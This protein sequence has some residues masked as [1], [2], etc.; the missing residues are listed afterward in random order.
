MISNEGS[1]LVSFVLIGDMKIDAET[2]L[3]ELH[4]ILIFPIPKLLINIQSLRDLTII[5]LFILADKIL[6]SLAIKF[7]Q[8]GVN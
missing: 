1:V 5:D 4:G 8:E 7:Y 3:K 6:L 2:K